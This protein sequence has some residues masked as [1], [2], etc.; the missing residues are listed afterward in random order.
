MNK[1]EGSRPEIS[2]YI[3]TY[4]EENK[5]EEALKSV[6]W[7]DEIVVFDS[8]STDRTVEISR[9]YTD[10]IVQSE[11]EGF[12][13]LR[14]DAVA[15]TRYQWIFSLD[16]DERCTREARDEIL[17]IISSEDAKDAYFVPRRNRFMGRKIKYSGWYPDYR[18]P[19]LFK[20]G[21]VTYKHDDPVHE[22]F[23]IHGTVGYMSNAIK[24]IPFT[25]LEQFIHK[26]DR[27]STLGAVKLADRKVKPGMG[28]AFNHGLAAFIRVF[29][30]Q[31]GF[32][33]GWPGFTIAFQ[34]FEYA[35]YKYAKLYEQKNLKSSGKSDMESNG[36]ENP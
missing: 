6:T 5:I 11:F 9:N 31:R 35:F 36:S 33:D 21:A 16:A 10:R 27:Y 19:Q 26:M 8:F 1:A 22:G 14:N 25:D 20:R 18:Q 13:K 34:N 17:S 12:G 28:K 2:V 15:N 7:A 23:T 24:Q 30:L 29:I 32:L 3:L 4:N